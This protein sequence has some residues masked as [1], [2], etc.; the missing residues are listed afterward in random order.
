M[1]TAVTFLGPQRRPTV[2]RVLRSLGV[3]G[4]IAAIA[5]GWQE[6]EADDGELVAVLGGDVVN[7]RLYSRW[8]Q[9]L[10]DDPEFARAEREH[11]GV[12]DELQ[13]LY[14]VQLDHAMQATMEVAQRADGNPRVAA[15]ALD[16]AIGILRQIDSSH[17]T[18]VC[19]L[20]GAFFDAWHPH[21]RPAIAS[22]RSEVHSLLASSECLVVAGGHVGE[23]TRTMHLFNIAPD[24]PSTVIAWSAGAMALSSRIVLFHDHAAQGPAQSEVYDQGLGVV[25]DVVPLPHARRRL[26]TDD[27]LRMSVLARRFAPARCLVLDDGVTVSLGSSGEL[28]AGAR[29]VGDDGRITEAAA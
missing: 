14:Q 1:S 17:L 24:L 11:R 4:R 27:G 9:V 22:Q 18:R 10:Q 13:L 16:D 12:L 28:P 3:T 8:M 7:L 15:G 25:P 2:D 26:R 29:V 5:A 6:R 19:E 20:H 21:S 23:L